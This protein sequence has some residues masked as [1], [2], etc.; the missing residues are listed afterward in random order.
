LKLKDRVAIVTGASS[1]IGSTI[2][3]HLAAAGA[4]VIGTYHSSREKA[5]GV[6]QTINAAGGRALCRKADVRSLAAMEQLATAAVEEFGRIDI[7][8]NNA[9]ITR[10][11]LLLS[12]TEQDFRDVVE[13]NLYGAFNCTRAVAQ[14]MMMQKRGRIINISSVAGERGGRG[15]TNY[16]AS[17]GG[18]NAFTRAAAIELA[19]KNITVNAIAP[20][21]IETEMSK[22]VMRRA[23]EIVLNH[24]P[25]KRLGTADEVA[26]LVVFLATDDAAYITGEIIRVDGGFRG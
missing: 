3:R 24:I 11:Q 20:G 18:L 7:L 16:A 4:V 14:Q 12:M 13:T 5:E 17:K 25:L 8:V 15:Q 23:Q 6:V 26:G 2:A 21:V 10:D 9:G 19:P 22:E 1:G